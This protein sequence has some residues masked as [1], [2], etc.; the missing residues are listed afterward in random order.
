[1]ASPPALP[2]T[3]GRETYTDP[4]ATPAAV[5]CDSVACIGESSAGFAYAIVSDPA[6]FAEECGRQ[7]VIARIRAP[8]WCDAA[9]VIDIDDL[10]TKGVHWLKWTAGQ[11]RFEVRPAIGSLER[12][13]RIR[14]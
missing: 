1:M 3:S 7:L 2:S 13:W 4:I 9:T 6:G 12:N 14:P 11:N 8:N 5:S 10:D